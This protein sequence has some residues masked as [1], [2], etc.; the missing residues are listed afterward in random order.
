VVAEH[1]L[2]HGFTLLR[3]LGQTRQGGACRSMRWWP[4]TWRTGCLRW[5]WCWRWWRWPW[6][7]PQR[8]MRRRAAP[9]ALCALLAWQLASGLSNVVLG[10]PIV[11]ALA[12]SAGAAGLV[13]VL[14][15]LWARLRHG[16]GPALAFQ[17][18]AAHA[19]RPRI[20]PLPGRP[21]AS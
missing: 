4:S 5:W 14:V 11:A 20:G 17:R 13:A 1:G 19:G 21:S 7:C 15:S 10:W 12:H 2:R 3:E 16:A 9:L 8:P 6:R 18:P